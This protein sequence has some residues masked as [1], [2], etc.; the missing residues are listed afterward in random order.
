MSNE[1]VDL[2]QVTLC[3]VDCIN[4][5]LAIRALQNSRRHCLFGETL[6][7]T[8]QHIECDARVAL[9]APIRSKQEYSQF[10]LKEL[11][12]YITTP[13][14]LLVQ[15][16][17]YVVAP[18]AWTD[19]FLAYD[20]IGARWPSYSDGMAVGNGGFSLRSKRLLNA[21]SSDS[22]FTPDA[23]TGEDELI[24]RAF[25]P[26]LETNYGIRFAPEDVADR[27]SV[28]I[29]PTPGPTFGFHG[30]FNMHRL[31]EDDILFVTEHAHERTVSTSEF[32]GFWARCSAGGRTSA[33]NQIYD[34][35]RKVFSTAI[36]EHVLANNGT[37]AADAAEQ[38]ARAE[39]LYIERQAV[40]NRD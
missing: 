10:I 12:Q 25:R 39:A 37:A 26:A 18:S 3:A 8:D 27:F 1:K 14:V 9:I 6:L 2:S 33:A 29:A 38:V 5:V 11:G 20:Y 13:W 24:C 4:P 30:L 17:G 23:T 40:S 7:L 36:I 21:L 31:P 35:I 16:D 19:E 22:G 15:W 32:I 28:E 34:R